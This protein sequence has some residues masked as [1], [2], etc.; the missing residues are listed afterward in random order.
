M[1]GCAVPSNAAEGML[2]AACACCFLQVPE[3]EP[4]YCVCSPGLIGYLKSPPKVQNA[5]QGLLMAAQE[6]AH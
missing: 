5:D 4:C 6:Q 3:Q 1:V 2:E